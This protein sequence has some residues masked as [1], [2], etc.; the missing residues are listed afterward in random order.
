MTGEVP[1]LSTHARR[2]RPCSAPAALAAGSRC[3]RAAPAALRALREFAVGALRARVRRARN[4]PPTAGLFGV[5]TAT[6][7]VPHTPALTG[8]PLS[9]PN[10]EDNDHHRPLDQQ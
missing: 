3:A 2:A 8:A 10:G 5:D 9:T 1:S 4:P 6:P 7:P